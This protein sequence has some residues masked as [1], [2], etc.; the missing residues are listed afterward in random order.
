MSLRE[1]ACVSSRGAQSTE[2][3]SL[4]IGYW[5]LN[6]YYYYYYYYY[7]GYQEPVWKGNQIHQTRPSKK[8]HD[9]NHYEGTASHH[10]RRCYGHSPS[11]QESR[12]NNS[13]GSRK[14]VPNGN[15]DTQDRLG[16][17]NSPSYNQPR[18]P[19]RIRDEASQ[20]LP[21]QMLQISEIQSHRRDMPCQERYLWPLRR[22]PPYKDMCG[23]RNTNKDIT[24]KVN[25]C[26]DSH[27]TASGRCP[28]RREVFQ[29]MRKP[30]SPDRN[31]NTP[32]K[33]VW[34]TQP[35]TVQNTRSRNPRQCYSRIHHHCP[36]WKTSRKSCKLQGPGT[37]VYLVQ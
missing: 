35:R 20:T 30:Q 19:G 28:Y 17:K 7:Y 32:V 27:S 5:T 31:T 13:L 2:L 23:N 22:S 21:S 36:R 25:D 11:D 1:H 6:N 8:I 16:K 18:N 9:S 4:Y 34:Q 14:Q 12:N 24:V 3:V 29:R 26:K 33:Y 10:T 15:Q 37:F